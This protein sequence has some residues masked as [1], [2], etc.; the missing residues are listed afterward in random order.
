MQ[1]EQAVPGTGGLGNIGATRNPNEKMWLFTGEYVAVFCTNTLV[2]WRKDV[3]CASLL[4]PVGVTLMFP[5]SRVK[6][7]SSGTPAVCAACWEAHL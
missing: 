2:G 7:R 1:V 6:K 3:G 4:I 5:G